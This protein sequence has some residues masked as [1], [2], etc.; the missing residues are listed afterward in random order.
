MKNYVLRALDKAR[1]IS[2]FNFSTSKTINGK[3]FKIPVINGT[4]HKMV[5][6]YEDWYVPFLE[7]ILPIINGT[8]VDVG[9]NIG[10]TL[11]K[12]AAIDPSKKY[13]GFEPNP[14][15]YYYAN[16]LAKANDLDCTIYPV[17]LG[18]VT[19]ILT[20]HMDTDMASGASVLEDFRKNKGRYKNKLLVPIF[21][22]DDLLIE[23]KEAIGCIKADVEGAELEAMQGLTATI[24][25]HRPII[26]LE[27]LP[28]YSLEHSN[29]VYRK[30]RQDKLLGLMKSLGYDLYLIDED[31]V[32]FI[33]LDDIEVHGDMNKTNY[34]FIPAEN[35]KLTRQLLA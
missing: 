6:S 28:V 33:K 15:A 29:G 2:R 22:G 12:V 8:F 11:L 10:Q 27:I 3:T 18:D 17:G 16:K 35:D 24:S 31:E 20:L 30:E 34:L 21:K 25:K 7:K 9:V 32:K 1:L 13:I 23:Q 14:F 19:T 26:V 5:Y 4:G